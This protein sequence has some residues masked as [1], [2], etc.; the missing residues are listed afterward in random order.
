LLQNLVNRVSRISCESQ[1]SVTSWKLVSDGVLNKLLKLY[2]KVHL[3]ESIY[4]GKFNAIFLHTCMY[5]HTK[6]SHKV[7][8]RFV[9]NLAPRVELWPPGEKLSPGVKLSPRGKLCPL[10]VKLDPGGWRSSVCPS[11]LLNIRECSP[12]RV[13]V[14]V[15]IPPGGQLYPW[16]QTHDVKN[17][18]LD[19][20][21][22]NEPG[23]CHSEGSSI[24]WCEFVILL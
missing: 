13:N 8:H 18:P 3:R 12:L 9:F 22:W 16:G 20:Q 1:Q 24:Y 6:Y 14:G 11:I 4:D 19:K 2:Y 10:G 21:S 15:S 5:I 7:N 23:T 17:W